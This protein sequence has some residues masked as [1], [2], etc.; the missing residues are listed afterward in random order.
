[1]LVGAIIHRIET[2]KNENVI[3]IGD[4]DHSG[5]LSF[6]RCCSGREWDPG[7]RPDSALEQLE[8]VRFNLQNNFFLIFNTFI[9]TRDPGVVDQRSTGPS[10]F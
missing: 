10:R 2:L 9:Q 3:I 8:Q 7:G 5:A 6:C 1:V 4:D